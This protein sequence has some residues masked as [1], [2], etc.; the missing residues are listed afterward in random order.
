M[1]LKDRDQSLRRPLAMTTS[2]KVSPCI[3][4]PRNEYMF[5]SCVTIITHAR[6]INIFL[7]QKRKL[8]KWKPDKFRAQTQPCALIASFPL[9]PIAISSFKMT[10]KPAPPPVTVRT[11]RFMTNRLLSRKQ[12]VMILFILFKIFILSY[13]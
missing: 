13:P 6:E 3:N 11:R 12:F 7:S 2:N 5:I 1:K 8:S 9:S 10:D 4:K